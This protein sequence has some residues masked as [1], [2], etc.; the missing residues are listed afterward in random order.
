MVSVRKRRCVVFRRVDVGGDSRVVQRQIPDVLL[1]L[2]LN[3][4]GN[5]GSGRAE[6]LFHHLAANQDGMPVNSGAFPQDFGH[7]R[8]D[9]GIRREKRRTQIA[10]GT[11]QHWRTIHW[12]EKCGI[13]STVEHVTQSDLERAELPALGSGIDDGKCAMCVGDRFELGDI[14][15]ATT[16]TRSACCC[17]RSIIA[18]RKVLTAGAP[19]ATGGQGRSALSRPIRVDSPAARMTPQIPAVWG[20]G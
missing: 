16:M 13:A 6:E 19:S 8:P 9:V 1:V 2:V 20:M 7:D 11:R 3:V 5:G 12:D 17:S 10:N 14:L 4:A 15:P 18:P